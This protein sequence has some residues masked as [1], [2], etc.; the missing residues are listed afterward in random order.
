MNCAKVA[1][2][3]STQGRCAGTWGVPRDQP[4]RNCYALALRGVDCRWDSVTLGEQMG[5]RNRMSSRREIL[6][7]AAGT[8]ALAASGLGGL[9][10]ALAQ[11]AAAFNPFAAA[12]NTGPSSKPTP[13]L[14]ATASAPGSPYIIPTAKDWSATSLL[15][16]GNE[17]KGYRMGGIPDGLGAFDNRDGTITLLMNHELAAG[18]GPARAH[19]GKGAYVSRWVIDKNT[20]E[21]RSGADFLSSPSKLMLWSGSG[22]KAASA[23][24]G[25]PLD[26]GRLCS[27]DLAPVSAFYNPR[28]GKGYNGRI[29][30]NGEE[31]GNATVNRAFAWVVA[32]GTAYELPAFSFGK[33]NDNNDPPPSW[34]NLVAHPNTG[35]TTLVMAMSDGGTYQTYVYL[36]TKRAEGSPIEKAGLAG[37]KLY[38]LAVEGVKT[39][40]RAKNIGIGK[41]LVGKG[42]GLRIGLA[43]PNKG[44]TF[45][46]PEDGAWDPNRPN[47]FYFV[48][49]DRNNFAADGTV[50]EGQ[51]VNQIGRSRLWGVTFDDVRKIATDGKPTAKMEMLLDGTEG[52][53]MF[54][55]IAIDRL[56]VIYLCEDPGNSRHN[57]K[58]W[59]YDTRNGAFNTIMRFDPDKFGDVV[60]KTYKAPVAP[61]VDD[62]ETSGIIDVTDLFTG[63]RW[64]RR[65]R[66]GSSR[67]SAGALHLRHQR[68]DRRRARGR[69]PAAASD[70][71][72]LTGQTSLRLAAARWRRCRAPRLAACLLVVDAGLR[73]I[74]QAAKPHN[75]A[76]AGEFA[77]QCKCVIIV[78]HVDCRRWSTSPPTAARCACRGTPDVLQH[79]CGPCRQ[80]HLQAVPQAAAS[81]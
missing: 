69:R 2:L 16:T 20:L 25:K 35:D 54:D 64:Y 43:E 30:L 49:T 36:G 65:G 79:A 15:T 4:S 53:D 26:M 32:D 50:R 72:V 51:D 60:N 68:Q 1:A 62:K 11:L 34:E 55:N 33:P 71:A 73:A 47:V 3:I 70:E 38:S 5:S 42:K 6:K 57:G 24:D 14:G 61:F 40:D 7:G 48:T 77:L 76:F 27:A 21:I 10:P 28:T 18:R 8:A 22:W 23:S 66:E 29:F 17:V 67:R 75:P 81:E 78:A 19:G 80:P 41:S 56:G 63:A 45:L 74:E 58:I 37:G 39:E 31:S 13:A 9:A 44:T 52:G 59:A 46:R 12:V